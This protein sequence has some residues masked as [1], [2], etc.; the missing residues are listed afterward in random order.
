VGIFG[1]SRS[2]IGSSSFFFVSGTDAVFLTY[3]AISR[4]QPTTSGRLREERQ[5]QR[6]VDTVWRLKM[7]GFSR[8]SL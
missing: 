7:E 8:I 5:R 1:S 4:P 2:F 3:L 6:A